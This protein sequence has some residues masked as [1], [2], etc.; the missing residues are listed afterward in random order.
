MS[1]EDIQKALQ[2]ISDY[3]DVKYFCENGM[4]YLHAL[5]FDEHQATRLRIGRRGKDLLPSYPGYQRELVKNV[6]DNE[7]VGAL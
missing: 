3:T 1:L 6:Q 2:E 7:R 4:W 5:K